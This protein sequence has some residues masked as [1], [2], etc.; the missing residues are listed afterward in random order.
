MYEEK[1]HVGMGVS[2]CPVCGVEHDEVVLLDMRLQKTLTRH[3][4]NGWAM[5]A[6]HSRL[7]DEGYIALAEVKNQSRP[8]L[9]TADRTG[10]ICHVREAAWAKI[11]DVPVPAQGLAFVEIGT[12]EKLQMLQEKQHD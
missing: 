1:S 12:I 11:F 10:L 9:K 4:F 3:M 6:E 5:C 8:T 2:V 7:K